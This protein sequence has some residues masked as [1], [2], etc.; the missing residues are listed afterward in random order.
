L[1]EAI[2]LAP[3]NANYVYGRGFVNILKDDYD[4]AIADLTEA[5]RLDPTKED[6]WSIR[7]IA[8]S[9]RGDERILSFKKKAD[10]DLSIADYSEAIR[11]RPDIVSY[12]ILRGKAYEI[13]GL[14][15]KALADFRQ[16]LTIEPQNQ[17]AADNVRAIEDLLP[18]GAKQA[19]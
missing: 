19:R 4:R 7:A 11:L 16:A 5:I 6:A 12:F 14:L 1:N 18:G 17:V 10:Y 15:D 13:T 8:F 2:Q 3:K 9:K